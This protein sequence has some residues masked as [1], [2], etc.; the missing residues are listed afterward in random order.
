VPPNTPLLY[1][2]PDLERAGVVTITS[3]PGIITQAEHDAQ[4]ERDKQIQ[5][6]ARGA[7]AIR[8]FVAHAKAEAHKGIISCA[9]VMLRVLH[10]S[11]AG[12]FQV[13]PLIEPELL[14]MMLDVGARGEWAMFEK[15]ANATLRCRL[16][17]M[18]IF[19]C[20]WCSLTEIRPGGLFNKAFLKASAEHF[21]RVPA[22]HKLSFT[23]EKLV[24]DVLQPHK[25]ETM[26]FTDM[27]KG[28]DAPCN[29]VGA[30]VFECRMGHPYW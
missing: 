3:V 1:G 27:R 2:L 28:L 8:E 23:G 16:Y 25:I 17:L 21:F 5:V 12:R 18:R 22:L 4:L 26:N 29:I 30:G 15:L 19:Q 9:P 20:E 13:G 14:G 6:A 10:D 7:S 24:S 11:L